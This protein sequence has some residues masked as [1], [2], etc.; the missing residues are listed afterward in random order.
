MRIYNNY[1]EE[2]EDIFI[3]LC[4]ELYSD[5]Y[6][7]EMD[8]FSADIPFYHHHLPATGDILEIGCGS[9][10]VCRQL[11]DKK[12]KI[13]AIDISLPMLNKA[14]KTTSDSCRFLCMD[15]R[16]MAFS[17]PFDSIIIPYNTLNLLVCRDDILN[18]LHHC[19][20]CLIDSGRL[21]LQLYLPGKKLKEQKG[22]TFQFQMFDRPAGGKIIKEVLKKYISSSHIIEV[23]ERFRIRP[24]TAGQRNSDYSHC[25]TL[26]AFSFTSWIEFF[27]QTG[28]KLEKCFGS[29]ELKPFT[30]VRDSLL[31]AVFQK[32]S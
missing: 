30:C 23:E 18:C 8:A 32:Q 1:D 26:S 3:P 25:F 6:S 19:S 14:R 29:H 27:H 9:G 12:R 20:A 24:M 5:L 31:L 2:P 11:A 7:L 10:R 28:F 16:D 21:C 22:K 17:A 4:E 15:M 13:T